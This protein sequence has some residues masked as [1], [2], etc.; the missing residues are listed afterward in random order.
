MSPPRDGELQRPGEYVGAP[1]G[2][3]DCGSLSNVSARGVVSYEAGR[4]Q[5]RKITDNSLARGGSGF[6]RSIEV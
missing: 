3:H 4:Y 6:E 5:S 2:M 1:Q